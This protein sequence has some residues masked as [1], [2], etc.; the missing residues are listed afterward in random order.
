MTTHID[1]SRKAF[2]RDKFKEHNKKLQNEKQRKIKSCGERF[3]EYIAYYIKYAISGAAAYFARISDD[4]KYQQRELLLGTVFTVIAA[5][6]FAVLIV[7]Q[8]DR[9]ISQKLI[10]AEPESPGTTCS[11]V[12]RQNSFTSSF[13]ANGV[14]D[15]SGSYDPNTN[16]FQVQY[17][18]VSLNS[19]TYQ[20]AILRIK[21][22]V[23]MASNYI[24]RFTLADAYIGLAA[25]EF[26][27]QGDALGW[28][29][30]KITLS[31]LASPSV[32]FDGFLSQYNIT[33]VGPNALETMKCA[34]VKPVI[35]SIAGLTTIVYRDQLHSVD[36]PSLYQTEG[37]NSILNSPSYG[38]RWSN[39]IQKSNYNRLPSLHINATEHVGQPSIKSN[40]ALDI[41]VAGFSQD[42]ELRVDM[43]AMLM[44]VS[45]NL[46]MTSLQQFSQ[47]T[48]GSLFG[49]GP[50]AYYYKRYPNMDDFYC[51][52]DIN[53][54]LNKK[55][56][57]Q[58][59]CFVLVHAIGGT[60]SYALPIILSSAWQIK[61][62]G[63]RAL[64]TCPIPAGL[65]MYCNQPNF[66]YM[67]LGINNGVTNIVEYFAQ[68]VLNQPILS[69]WSN[70]YRAFMNAAFDASALN[71]QVGD[72]NNPADVAK[73]QTELDNA[74]DFCDKKCYITVLQLMGFSAGVTPNSLTLSGTVCT[75]N[76]FPKSTAW[77]NL[78][79]V[80]PVPLEESY[81]ECTYTRNQAFLQ[82]LG[83]SAGNMQIVLAL[84]T[85]AL[86]PLTV[87]LMESCGYIKPDT[88]FGS[89]YDN[90]DK[91]LALEE[92][93]LHLLRVRDGDNR[94]I[95]P[96]GDFERM[97]KDLLKIGR[98]TQRL[99]HPTSDDNNQE[100]AEN[101]GRFESE[102][103]L[104]R[105]SAARSSTASASVFLDLEPSSKTAKDKTASP[106]HA[107]G[108]SPSPW[109][110]LQKSGKETDTKPSI[111]K[112]N[113]Q[114]WGL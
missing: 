28:I 75:S 37:C 43:T 95:T 21:D 88:G 3:L 45:V 44:A 27:I 92:L 91:K 64:C 26:F 7:I 76:A 42:V 114:S 46:G 103:A 6:V 50:I 15:S 55:G 49:P 29:D 48:S 90:E 17:F 38:Y 62:N 23:D 100:F 77:T 74:L 80:P 10:S 18:N 79:A 57:P 14:W 106:L 81:Y 53:V 24:E 104:D 39:S 52:P 99:H 54:V 25:F 4:Q 40:I 89:E 71:G 51:I 58:P 96:D 111:E 63:K 60:G 47:R 34:N 33:L 41:K 93:A 35:S 85:F 108:Q 109:T 2:I 61:G 84:M 112:N 83:I 73:F 59:L 36:R 87:Y 19:S 94:G 72:Y 110:N 16:L 97:A 30:S 98:A 13:D 32:M 65:E 78:A 68:I 12:L 101:G 11:V 102:G 5:G 70:S 67:L 56:N 31:T 105:G 69:G 66:S 107:S 20:T 8:Y 82:S 1:G 113:Q 86:F 22:E 9:I